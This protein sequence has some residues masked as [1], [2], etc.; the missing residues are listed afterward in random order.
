MPLDLSRPAAVL[1]GVRRQVLRR[2][3]L[4]AA[5]LT[6]VAVASGLAATAERPPASVPVVVAAHDLPAGEVLGADDLATVAFAPGSVPARL[7]GPSTEVTG[8][9]LAAPL[10]RGAPVTEVG[11]VGPAMTGD[12]RDLRALPVRLPDAGAVALLRVGDEVDL[13]AT[14]PQAGDTATVA[15]AALV[16][17]IPAPDEATGPTGLSGRLVV[18]GVADDEVGRL[19]GAATRS[20]LTFTWS[21]R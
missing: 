16:L 12:R 17:A 13:V 19:A 5:V 11:L 20:V 1:G 8:R 10:T 3:R 15:A 18:V 4:L 9:V 21:R 6:A 2:R 14:D 7:A